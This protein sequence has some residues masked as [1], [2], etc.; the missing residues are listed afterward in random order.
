MDTTI[1]PFDI[2]DIDDKVNLPAVIY[3]ADNTKIVLEIF[4]LEEKRTV[5]GLPNLE[6]DNGIRFNSCLAPV[7]MNL[8]HEYIRTNYKLYIIGTIDDELINVLNFIFK[9]AIGCYFPAMYKNNNFS[10]E[11]RKY[12][13]FRG[14]NKLSKKTLERI[15][16]L[17]PLA[18]QQYTSNTKLELLEALVE[19]AYTKFQRRRANGAFLVS[20]LES[21]FVEDSR[22]RDGAISEKLPRRMAGMRQQDT[23]FR[24]KIGNLYKSRCNFFHEGKGTFSEVDVIFLEDEVFWAIEQY[25][26]NPINFDPKILDQNYPQ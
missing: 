13:A 4:T 9:I 18:L 21:L 2:R 20:I 16:T 8:V 19:A 15:K 3:E 6:V 5:F 23:N 1:L 25:I 24:I 14:I 22:S 7:D 26:K 11:Y 12:I 17:I 10:F